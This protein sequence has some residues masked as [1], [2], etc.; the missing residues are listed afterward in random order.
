MKLQAS[1]IE[2][3]L[4]HPDPQIRAVLVYG[5]DAGLVR[6]RAERLGLTV[7]PD[8]RDPFRVA[9]LPASTLATDPA[10]LADEAAALSMTGGRR[11][12]RIRDADEK[13]TAAFIAVMAAPPPGDSLIIAEAGDLDARSR[14]RA[15]FEGAETGAALPCYVEEEGN[16]ERIIAG[17]LEKENLGIDPDALSLLASHLVGDRQMARRELEKLVLYVGAPLQ[18]PL[19][20]SHHVTLDDVQ[21]CIGDNASLSLDDAAWAAA[22]GDLS[23]LERSL[24]HLFGEGT[25]PVGI[26]RAAQ[27]HFLRLHLVRSQ[28]DAGTSLE[29]AVSGLKPPVFFKFKARFTAQAR[30]WPLA[31]LTAA[32]ERLTLTEAECKRTGLPDHLLCSRVLLQLAV[33]ARAATVRR[34]SETT[35]SRS[36]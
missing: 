27:R 1:R 35:K 8:L 7:T 15:A 22:D 21:A 17:I 29:I 31:R 18:S 20:R 12:V 33:L 19:G 34:S 28:M 25:S 3:F 2:A 16:L 32:L 11:L 5:P 23:A 26:L 14:L 13:T 6:E 9:V 24:D 4:R 36:P 30:L 10:S